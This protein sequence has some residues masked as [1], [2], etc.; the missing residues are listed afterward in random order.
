M[1]HRCVVAAAIPGCR[2]AGLPSPAEL[3]ARNGGGVGRFGAWFANGAES[4]RQD[5]A[6][7]VRQ[8]CLTPRWSEVAR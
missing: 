8:G 7:Y 4:G 5:A 1:K 2:G 3:G 6:R